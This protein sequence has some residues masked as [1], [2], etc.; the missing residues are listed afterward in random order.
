MT[1]IDHLSVGV[2]ALEQGTQFYDGLLNTV[3]IKKLAQTDGFAAYGV[4]T[5]TFLIMLPHNGDAP[6]HGNGVH[7]AFVAPNVEAVNAFYKFALDNGGVC[8]GAPGPRD[9]YPMEVHTAFV[10]DPFGNKLEVIF[11]GFN[12]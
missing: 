8:E 6:T 11:N 4:N 12:A 2:P 1:I 5:P 3:G 7:I 10:R 9:G